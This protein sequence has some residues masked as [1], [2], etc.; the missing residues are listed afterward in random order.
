VAPLLFGGVSQERSN[1][2]QLARCRRS[3][4]PFGTALGQEG[5]Q[6]LRT[7]GEQGSIPNRIASI[8]AEEGDEAVRGSNVC[9]DGMR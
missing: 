5:A 3:T 1:S 2:R 6:V 9:A 8:L 7:D 4:Q